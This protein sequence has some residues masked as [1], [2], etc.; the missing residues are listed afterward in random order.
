MYYIYHIPTFTHKDG[1]V[2][3]IGCSTN[4][5]GRVKQQGYSDYEILEE[6]TCIDT[7]SK[8]EL[9][10]QKEYG[11]PIDKGL[12]S[13]NKDL[14]THRKSLDY[15]KEVGKN[16]FKNKTG[17]FSISKERK[18]E[19][20]K[21]SGKIQGTKLYKEKR[22]LFGVSKEQRIEWAHLGKVTSKP[23]LQYDLNGNLLNE[24]VSQKEAERLTGVRQTYISYNC[25][26]T[27]KTAGGFVWK[28]KTS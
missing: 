11:Y 3:K 27:Q 8:R 9:E 1:S 21:I 25:I 7:V 19:L 5:N 13:K 6:H 28:F 2:G 12:Y 14:H 18:S 20:S 22:G 26:G 4:P 10:L 17:F 15:L 16:S 24:Y 23:I